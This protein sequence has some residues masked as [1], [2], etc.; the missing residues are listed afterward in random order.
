MLLLKLFTL[1]DDIHSEGNEFQGFI[2]LA[3]KF[4]MYVFVVFIVSFH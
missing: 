3:V 4:F 2:L 1:S